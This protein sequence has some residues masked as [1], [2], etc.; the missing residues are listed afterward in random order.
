MNESV[1]DY[2]SFRLSKIAQPEYRHIL[3]LLGWP[4]FFILYFLTENLIPNSACTVVHCALDDRIPFNELFMI[5]YTFWYFEIVFSLAYFFFHN[6]EN[7]KALQTYIIITQMVAMAIY[8]AFPTRQDMRPLTFPRDNFLTDMVKFL[9][10]TDDNTGVCPS[11]HVAYAIGMASAWFKEKRAGRVWKCF[12]GIMT[13]FICISVA[14]V[15]QHS[16]VDIIAALPL[17]A[18]A[19]VLAYGKCYWKPRLATSRRY[20]ASP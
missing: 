13:V 6:V 11:L 12:I 20:I 8:I 2:R 17:C 3:L 19:E 4:L 1:P 5:P 10:M 9:Y 18:L 15:K 16:V 14:F 7:F